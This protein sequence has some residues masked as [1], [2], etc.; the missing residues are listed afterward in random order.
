M[1][2][3]SDQAEQHTA[4]LQQAVLVHPFNEELSAGTLAPERFK[5]YLAQDARYLAG[6]ARALAVAAARAPEMADVAFYAGAAHESIVVEREMH[7][8]YFQSYNVNLD[9]IEASPTCLAYTSFLLAT[10][11]TGSYA[12]LAATLLPCFTIYLAVGNDIL[13]RQR[14]GN[15]YRLW[16]DTYANDAFAEVVRTCRA[17]VD[18]AAEAADERT[19]QSMLGHF[20]LACEYEW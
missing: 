8:T 13:A 16:I 11:Q 4:K 2:G 19:R 10:A 5:F 14:T 20:T 15:P 7:E 3:F 12:E 18:R 6:F 17:T 9:D 1:T